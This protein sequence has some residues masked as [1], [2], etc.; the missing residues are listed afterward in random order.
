MSEKLRAEEIELFRAKFASMT[1]LGDATRNGL[2]ALCD[3]ALAGLEVQPRPLSEVP[4]KWTEEPVLLWLRNGQSV[5][6]RQHIDGAWWHRMIEEEKQRGDTF[7]ITHYLPL[8]SLP[9][10][11]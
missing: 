9:E 10:P 6:L 8:S 3:L 4:R 11:K 1:Y 7:Y 2:A 5:E